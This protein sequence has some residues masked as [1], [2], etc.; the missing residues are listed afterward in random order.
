MDSKVIHKN[1]LSNIIGPSTMDGSMI[2]GKNYNADGEKKKFV[3]FEVDP[4]NSS[5]SFNMD[6]M[7]SL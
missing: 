5:M 3:V 7:K 1:R 2:D 6:E 4:I